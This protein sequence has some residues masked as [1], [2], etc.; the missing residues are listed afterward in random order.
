MELGYHRPK[1]GIQ[2]EDRSA[3]PYSAMRTPRKRAVLLLFTLALLAMDCRHVSR[4]SLRDTEDREVSAECDREQRCTL[5]QTAGPSVGGNQT[6]LV[7]RTSGAL[8]GLCSVAPASE[9]ESPS[10]CRALVCETD[11]QCPP[12]HGMK[13]GNCVNSLCREPE[14]G[15]AVED[16][17]MLCLAGTGLGRGSEEQVARYAMALNCGTPCTVPATCRQP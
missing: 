7:L 6:E 10:D 3:L 15:L 17:V 14:H 8:V 16:A 1:K 2:L 4:R 11:E 13:H 12:A 9:P 5:E